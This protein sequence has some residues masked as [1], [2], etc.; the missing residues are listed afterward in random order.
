MPPE[1]KELIIMTRNV[2]SIDR[3]VRIVL[4]LGLLV[5]G[6]ASTGSIRLVELIAGVVLL[7]TAASGFCLLYRL[8]GISSCKTAQ[9][10]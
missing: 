9:Q 5:A 4:G 8:F 2:G 1:S 3:V 6:V 7:F 10:S